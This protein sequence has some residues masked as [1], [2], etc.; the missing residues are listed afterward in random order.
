MRQLTPVMEIGRKKLPHDP[1]PVVLPNP[2]HEV[3]F[4]TV[5]CEERHANQLALQNVWNA[6]H[7]TAQV[8]EAAGDWKVSLL[9]AMPDHWHGLVSFPGRKPMEKVIGQMK[10]WLAKSRGIRWQSG[11]FDHRLRSSESAEEK[12]R[13]ILMNPVRAG[14][15]GEGGKWPYVMDRF[16]ER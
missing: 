1:P 4:I 10:G 14:L 6:I 9:L 5:C 7:E 16:G 2:E 3:Y 13:Y 12:R 11:F 8:R 15:I